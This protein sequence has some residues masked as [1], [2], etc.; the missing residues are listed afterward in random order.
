VAQ[1]LTRLLVHVIYSTKN[2]EPLITSEIAPERHR[3]LGGIA[4]N[5]TSPALTIGGAQD[6]VHLLISLAKTITISDLLM[7]L[8]RDS[9]KWIKS[10]GP[11]FA[12][13]AWQEG[14][15]AFTIGESQVEAFTRYIETQEE[16]HRTRSFQ[17]EFRA[18]LTR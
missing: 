4:R 16:H 5:H 9:S 15:G 12:D 3:Y 6:H 8:K 13:F 14:Y 10:K 17:D 11:G 2:R 7:H 1:T 18:I